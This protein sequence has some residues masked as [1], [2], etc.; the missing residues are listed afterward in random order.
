MS[1]LFDALA[2][3]VPET[4]FLLRQRICNQIA[5]DPRAAHLWIRT[6]LGEKVNEYVTRMRYKDT[7]GGGMEIQ[8]FAQ[9]YK[10]R[11]YVRVLGTGRDIEF[12]PFDGI[13]FSKA[14][15]T[16]NGSHYEADTLKIEQKRV[17]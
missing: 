3:F 15:L 4:S 13:Y 8:T 7:W 9:L 17:V 14:H 10:F 16:W 1:C 12:V 6:G 5:S 2:K 11:V